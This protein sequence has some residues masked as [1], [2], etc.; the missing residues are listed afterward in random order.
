MAWT[1]SVARFAGGREGVADAR[2]LQVEEDRV[3]DE[4]GKDAP[5]LEADDEG[6]R[7]AGHAGAGERRD[8]QVARAG[9][10][11]TDGHAVDGRANEIQAVGRPAVDVA[12]ASKIGE[13][14]VDGPDGLLVELAA[15]RASDR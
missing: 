10:V 1:D 13:R 7:A 3:L 15:S 14:G 11:G 8:V 2:A 6:V 4:R 5:F 9:A 12:E